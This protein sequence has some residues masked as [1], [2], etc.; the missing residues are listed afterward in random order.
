[1]QRERI[2][3]EKDEEEDHVHCQSQKVCGK[4]CHRDDDE[5]VFGKVP[6]MFGSKE[7]K[8]TACR[9]RR[10]TDEQINV[11]QVNGTGLPGIG[12]AHFNDKQHVFDES[13]HHH[14]DLDEILP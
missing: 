10:R 12:A 13:R 4:G 9:T 8:I 1:M 11:G 7:K 6:A 14:D 3:V 5:D 2:V